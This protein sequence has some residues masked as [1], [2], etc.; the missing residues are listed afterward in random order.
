L[1][2]LSLDWKSTTA[3]VP[4]D[5]ISAVF[6]GISGN[7]GKFTFSTTLKFTPEILAFDGG[8]YDRIGKAQDGLLKSIQDY[9]AIEKAAK[10]GLKSLR[11]ALLPP[12]GD[13]CVAPPK[14]QEDP[15]LETP[16]WGQYVIAALQAAKDATNIEEFDKSIKDLSKQISDSTSYLTTDQLKDLQDRQKTLTNALKE[17]TVLRDRFQVLV[18]A[19][20]AVLEKVKVKVKAFENDPTIT[21]LPP[22]DKNYQNQVWLLNA[23][24]DLRAPAKRASAKELTPDPGSLGTLADTPEKQTIATITVQFQSSPRLEVSTGLMVPF[25]PY[26]S[27]SVAA[28]AVNGT[29]I[30]N[31]V[32]QT[33]TYTVIPMVS[34]NIRLCPEYS[35]HQQR[36]TCFGSIAVG[37]NPVTSAV[38]FGLG[39]SFSWRSIV[40]GINADIGRDTEL[41]GGF[42]V[43]QELPVNN[44]PKPLTNTVWT[45]KPAASLSVRIPL[46]GSK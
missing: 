7:L 39:P 8:V 26:H 14:T 13:I 20:T 27:Y 29:I 9:T 19:V 21:E 33:S 41:A 32:Q 37:Y 6:S 12:P 44:P 24:N 11:V 25:L 23:T 31:V 34:V 18:D 4:P 30:K 38:E 15:W 2:Q 35:L 43:G 46:G 5:V 22:R 28:V 40:I 16:A 45:V 10:P 36:A 42:K 1:E 17:R 3:V